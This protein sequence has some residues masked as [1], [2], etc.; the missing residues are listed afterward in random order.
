MH[1]KR[2]RPDASALR[3]MLRRLRRSRSPVSEASQG[4][5]AQEARRDCV[6]P[7][8]PGPS[9]SSA[10]SRAYGV[11]YP[12]TGHTWYFHRELKHPVIV[13]T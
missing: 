10:A 4:G 8:A 5:Q 1:S 7:V 2:I 6:P 3:A 13:R 11:T 9:W 12:A